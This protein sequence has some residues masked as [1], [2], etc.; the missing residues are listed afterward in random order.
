[1]TVAYVFGRWDAASPECA[2]AP[3]IPS[4]EVF[5]RIANGDRLT[6]RKLFARYHV[7]V[8]RWLLRSLGD[9]TL[10]ESLLNDVF[11]DV[12]RNAAFFDGRS[13]VSTWLLAIA[14]IKGLS[15][16]RTKLHS[17]LDELARTVPT[18]SDEPE[19]PLQGNRGEVLRHALARL[20]RQYGEVIDLVYYHGK[21]VKEA[22]QIV[23]TD[24]RTVKS[25]MYDARRRLA[26]WVE[27]RTYA[28]ALKSCS[29]RTAFSA[30]PGKG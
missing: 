21:S 27:L 25:R 20:S 28:L 6:M 3:D 5:R 18:A 2:A 11:L 19:L 16:R 22:A 1:M 10:A 4:D 13:S 26:E 24:E 8:Y 29:S 14:R 9:A 17:E 23:G 12:W 7:S 30:A 15:A